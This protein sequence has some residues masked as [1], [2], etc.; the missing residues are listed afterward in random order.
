MFAH[1][2]HLDLGHPLIALYRAF[3]TTAFLFLS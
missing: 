3:R 2:Y 1:Y